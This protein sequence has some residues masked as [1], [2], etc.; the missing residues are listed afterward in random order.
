MTL[1]FS[2]FVEKSGFI[3]TSGQVHLGAGGKL[4]GETIEE[5]VSQVMNNLKEVLESA[6]VGFENVVK[7]TVYITDIEDYGKVS[8]SYATFF[9]DTYPAREIVCVKALPLGANV[10]ISL[11]ASK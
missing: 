6:G 11:V 2:P 4:V 3:Y 8:D 10:E 5:K 9:S 1:P 7:A